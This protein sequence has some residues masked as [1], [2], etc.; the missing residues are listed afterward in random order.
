MELTLSQN[1][2]KFWLGLLFFC[3][4]SCFSQNWYVNDSLSTGDIFT[5]KPGDIN[6]TGNSP[7][8]PSNSISLIFSKVK[9][10]DHVYIDTGIYPEINAHGN[11]TLAT[12]E[13]VIV[14]LFTDTYFQKV[15]IPTEKK[16]TAE[17]FF[18]VND[19]PVSR[20]IYLKSKS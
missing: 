11:L 20:E 14:H 1:P 18:I 17:E 2:S 5:T 4:I 6:S 19:K 3:T 13:G 9:K 8:T 10:G 12:P 15:E 16:A 7:E